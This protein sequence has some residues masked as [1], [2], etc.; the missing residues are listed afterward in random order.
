MNQNLWR[1]FIPKPK[2]LLAKLLV[3]YCSFYQSNSFHKNLDSWQTFLSLLIVTD[4]THHF[5]FFFNLVI[6]V[7]YRL[8]HICQQ[9]TSLFSSLK[10]LFKIHFQPTLQQNKAT[11][12]QFSGQYL[13][14][15]ATLLADTE[16][17]SRQEEQMLN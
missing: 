6:I 8:T 11:P 4:L 17:F 7:L 9:P 3:C 14:Q 15:Y 10:V 16:V 2:W 13:G 5:F 1:R 12:D